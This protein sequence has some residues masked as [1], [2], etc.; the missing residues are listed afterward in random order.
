MAAKAIRK[1]LKRIL[2]V[3]RRDSINASVESFQ[4]ITHLLCSRA[5]VCG[6][7]RGGQLSRH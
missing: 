3:N 2:N 7:E 1:L 5:L 6:R 4:G